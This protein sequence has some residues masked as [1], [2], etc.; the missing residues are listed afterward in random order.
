MKRK[1]KTQISPLVVKNQNESEIWKFIWE[2]FIRIW[3]MD[4]LRIHIQDRI[5]N[6]KNNINVVFTGTVI[7]TGFCGGI[8]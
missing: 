8:Y 4:S 5:L 7:G 6:E 3:Y 1:S 2:V